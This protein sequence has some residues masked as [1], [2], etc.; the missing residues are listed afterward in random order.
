M[1]LQSR[2]ELLASAIGADIKSLR[3]ESVH[4]VQTAASQAFGN[5]ATYL[6][7][8][9]C[10]IPTGKI[11]AGTKYRCKFNIVKTAAGTAAPVFTVRVGTA[12]TTADTARATL[13]MAAQTAVADEGVVELEVIFK[14]SGASAVLQAIATLGHR[15]AATGLSTSNHDTKIATS[16]AFDATVAG[17]KIGVA[18][19]AGNQAAWTIS[20]V[21]AELV[22]LAA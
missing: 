11:K 19:D 15:L 4:N 18:I 12:G 21:S 6:T 9:D 1:S 17:L 2:L 14:A 16:A 7:G 3:N 13:T 20:F 8:S 5:G 10:L 22:N